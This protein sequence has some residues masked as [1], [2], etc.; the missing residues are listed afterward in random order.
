M[1]NK[2]TL[3]AMFPALL[4]IAALLV[5]D[6]V[7]KEALVPL[8]AVLCVAAVSYFVIAT[9]ND[10]KARMEEA[11]KAAEEAESRAE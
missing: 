2:K 4:L 7:G 6:K 8:L 10:R 9:Y 1:L 5:Y 3:R 11:K